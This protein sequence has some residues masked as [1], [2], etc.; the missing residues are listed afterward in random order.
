MELAVVRTADVPMDTSEECSADFLPRFPLESYTCA[1]IQRMNT[2]VDALHLNP[3]MRR[4]AMMVGR[5]EFLESLQA[6]RT[7]SERLGYV[8][9]QGTAMS[10]QNI[11]ESLIVVVVWLGGPLSDDIP[12]VLLDTIN[13]SC[14]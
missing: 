2:A 4:T 7:R 9:S 8:V 14:F 12:H 5:V 3:V 11:I 1:H 10:V 13:A 6:L